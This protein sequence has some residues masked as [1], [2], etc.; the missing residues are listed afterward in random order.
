MTSYLRSIVTMA[1]IVSEMNDDFSR[2]RKIF[3]PRVF[4][5][6]LTE[7]PLELGISARSLN[8]RMMDLPDGRKSFKIDLAVQ[9]QYRRVTDG[10]TDGKTPHDNKDRAVQ[11]VA[12]VKIL[13]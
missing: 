8:S 2:N 12:R 5:T 7:V 4:C 1:R 3:P 11:N 13:K 6:P 9:T 10:L